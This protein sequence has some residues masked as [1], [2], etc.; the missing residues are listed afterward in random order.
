MQLVNISMFVYF[1]FLDKVS[2]I[3]QP[4]YTVTEQ[5]STCIFSFYL[6]S[7]LSVPDVVYIKLSF[8]KVRILKFVAGT[9]TEQN[10]IFLG[11]VLSF[12]GKHAH[13]KQIHTHFMTLLKVF[14]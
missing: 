4:D 3:K 14:I 1:S 6:S 11:F 2:Q 5:V 9:P 7:F 12:K 13:I 8:V 10:W